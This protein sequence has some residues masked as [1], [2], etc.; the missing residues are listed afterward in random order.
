MHAVLPGGVHDHAAPAAAH[1]EQPHAGLQ[2]Q[3]AGDQVELVR[4]G[5]LE[6][7]VLGRVAGAG[8]GHRRAEHPLV[9]GV[10]DVVVMRDRA[11]VGV[12]PPGQPPALDPDFLRRRGDSRQQDTGSAQLTEQLDPF[13][14][15]HVHPL[16]IDHACQRRVHVTL[17]VQVPGYVRAGEPEPAGRL[18]QVG[19]RGR[20]ADG[21]PYRRV[22]RS[23]LAPV[24]GVERHRGV[25]PRDLLEHVSQCH[26]LDPFVTARERTCRTGR[27]AGPPR[28]THP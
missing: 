10:G 27:P 16:R 25:G 3:L 12:P 1:V 8:V 2:P 19:H 21:D 13:R 24:I 7:G 20:R 4:L 6:G 11:G 26:G 28:R 17:D 18:G 9:E 15:I 22:L 5:F 23:C 14:K